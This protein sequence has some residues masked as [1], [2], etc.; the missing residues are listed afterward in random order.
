MTR[1]PAIADFNIDAA[2][3]AESALYQ[4]LGYIEMLVRERPDRVAG[5][6]VRTLMRREGN[7]A[8]RAL[9]GYFGEQFGERL[10]CARDDA[11]LRIRSQFRAWIATG[12]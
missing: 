12:A 9:R 10:L 8:P 4:F 3:R 11:V 5:K 6:T 2:E 7:D 1:G